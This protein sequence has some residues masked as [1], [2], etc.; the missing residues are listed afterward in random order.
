MKDL[1]DKSLQFVLENYRKGMFDT[2]KA[3]KKIN[4]GRQG[5]PS[6]KK[7]LSIYI[8][9]CCFRVDSGRSFYA[10]LFF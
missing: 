8:G 1:E 3:L 4:G 9:T 2:R 10:F 7:N 6:V 5:F